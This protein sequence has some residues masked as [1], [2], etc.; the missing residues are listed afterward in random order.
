MKAMTL[1]AKS[2]P[3]WDHFRVS[4]PSDPAQAKRVTLVGGD[5]AWDHFRVSAPSDPV[6][7]ERVTLVGGERSEL[8]I[9]NS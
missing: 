4:A 3:V 5:P 2:D 6:Q 9:A 7:A 8:W 1:A